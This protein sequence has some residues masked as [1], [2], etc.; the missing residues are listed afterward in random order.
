[1]FFHV[2]SLFYAIAVIDDINS[3]TDQLEQ[4]SAAPTQ[5]LWTA[6]PEHNHLEA[7]Q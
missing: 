1:M 4:E 2:S 5:V 6:T 3:F 7:A